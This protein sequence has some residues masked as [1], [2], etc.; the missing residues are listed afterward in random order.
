MLFVR[1]GFLNW[2]NEPSGYLKSREAV[3]NFYSCPEAP[4]EA[5]VRSTTV[6][7]TFHVH[8]SFK[9]LLLDAFFLLLPS[10]M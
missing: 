5:E 1:L 10:R 7:T 8:C 3:A 6:T 9:F 4:L 2:P